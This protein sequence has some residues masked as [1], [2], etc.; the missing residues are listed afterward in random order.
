[1][2][3]AAL[4]TV[5]G[6]AE[7][8]RA[9]RAS[10]A[11]RAEVRLDLL[12]PGE[13]PEGLLSLA[14][15]LPLLVSGNRSRITPGEV[16]L[17][18]R[19]QALGAWVDVPVSGD[20]PEDLF[21]LSTGRLVLSWH[22]GGPGPADPGAALAVLAARPAAVRKVVFAARDVR[23][24]LAV[25]NLLAAGGGG[26][27][28]CAFAMGLP[29]Q[30]SRILSLAWGSC[31]LYAAAPGCPPAAEGQPTLEEVTEA[32]ACL[33]ISRDTPLL[34]V[35]GWPLART[36]SPALHNRWLR[37]AG[38]A[39]RFLPIPVS[40]LEVLL[41]AAPGLDLRGLAV[42]HP[43]KADALALSGAASRLAR[44]AGAANT[45]RRGEGPSWSAA[46]TDVFGVRRALEGLGTASRVLVLGAGGAAAAVALALRRRSGVAV[47]SRNLSRSRSLASRLGLEAIPWE[48][49]GRA[50]WDL[51]VN[52][53]PSGQEGEDTPYAF[54]LRGRAVFDLV[55]R[56][57]GTPLLREARARGLSA[58]PGEAMLEAQARLQYRLF[59]GLRPPRLDGPE[60]VPDN[61][62][63]ATPR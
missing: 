56:E 28:L 30:M 38:L 12:A 4:P 7:A 63:R 25:R 17:L 58:V 44:A 21:G 59:T 35:A 8:A 3:T 48:E 13:D 57:G 32:Y 45:L 46:N 60:S 5:R 10:G 43:H 40:S 24:N 26:G 62:G 52:A 1:V 39:H 49:R 18:R 23:D 37:R 6:Q 51:L 53:T 33:G 29:G 42:T 47:A 15:D 55:V 61:G 14:G 22:A 11:D 19:A 31:A 34:G 50:P 54:P 16:G 9:A 41:E 2:A 20:L 36:G 27:D